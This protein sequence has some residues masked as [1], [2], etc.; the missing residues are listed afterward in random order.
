MEII[1][2]LEVFVGPG[3][4]ASNRA[5]D[6]FERMRQAAIPGL[7]TRLTD[8]S[9]PAAT[10]PRSI[11]AVPTYTLNGRVISL[12]NPTEDCLLDLIQEVLGFQPSDQG[13]ST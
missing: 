12:G 7:E 10:R 11:F 13:A 4:D 3:C 8:L 2:V 6:L 5:R 1:A 9:S